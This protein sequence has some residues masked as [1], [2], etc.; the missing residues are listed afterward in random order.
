MKVI[1]VGMKDFEVGIRTRRFQVMIILFTIISLGMTY[2]LKRLGVSASLYKTPF[3]M[4]FLSSFSNAFNYSVALLGILLGATTINGEKERGTLRIMASKPIYR[5]QI[6]LG[7]FL[8][9]AL[10]LG[11]SLGLF[12]ILTI[13]FAL[14]LGVTPNKDDVVMFL[15]TLPFSLL[16][17]LCFFSL[18]MLISTIIK[19]PKNAIV[20]GIFIFAFLSFVLPIIASVIALA[21]VGLPPIPSIPADASNLTEEELQ[22]LII[23]DPSYQEW[24]NELVKTTEGI[25]YISPNYHY[26]EIIRMIF[27]GKPQI[28]EV[29]SALAYEESIVEDRSIL[30]SLQLA[31]E[32]ILVLTIASMLFIGLSYMRFVKMDY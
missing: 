1:N 9:G 18:G 30:E 16:Y 2:N 24:L 28:S 12:Y 32:N 13:A 27:G 3:Q 23:Q 6:L 14:L 20:M 21:V 15:T 22:E 25:L 8:G 4:L 29:I 31:W 19:K 7:K 26:Q 5:D 17:A 11:A 10:I